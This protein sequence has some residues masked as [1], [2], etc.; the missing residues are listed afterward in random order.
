[1][2]SPI[3]LAIILPCYNEEEVLNDS[4]LKLHVYF[5]N[6][7]E[8]KLISE[9]S[10]LCFVND[11]SI[12]KTWDI[13]VQLKSKYQNVSGIKLSRN[14]GQQ[15][16]IF[17]AFATLIDNFDCYITI[18]VDLQDEISTIEKMILE[19][20]NGNSIVYGVRD[21]R[22]TDS[23]F[24]RTT[25]VYF[26]KVMKFLGVE[27]VYNHSEFRLLDN[28]SL[29]ELL[30]FKEVNLFLRG[31][32]PLLGFRTSK[33]FYKRQKR[34][35]GETKYPLSKMISLA[36]DGVSS[37]SIKPMRFVLVIGFITF[38]LSILIS[39]WMIYTYVSGKAIPGWFSTLFPLM[40]LS[41]VQMMSIGLLGEYIGKMFLEV[42]KRPR[43][44]IE[45]YI[46][47]EEEE[48]VRIPN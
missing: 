2:D 38:V 10:T 30:H 26:Y 27:T 3:E 7:L 4:F 18:D 45:E 13:I 5:N 31:I 34:E 22:S 44:I 16:A 14:F 46:N 29:S 42:K 8:R 47:N 25:A 24:K 36:W 43:F 12:D 11:G 40:L 15:N 1:M 19:F 37:F 28:K 35:A 48:E 21:D 20:N 39:F 17:A 32:V 23:F 9:K 33:V 41:G 6:L